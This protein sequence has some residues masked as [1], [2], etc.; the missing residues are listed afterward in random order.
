MTP[1]PNFGD[2]PIGPGQ[3]WTPS[4]SSLGITR[5]E[6]EFLAKTYWGVAK[7]GTL[8]AYKIV[9][10]AD[11]I[12]LTSRY[13]C[14]PSTS[15]G[16]SQYDVLLATAD[17]GPVAGAV[18]DTY[19]GGVPA[20][21]WFRLCVYAQKIKLRLGTTSDTRCTITVGQV[22]VCNADD[23]MFWLQDSTAANAAVQNRVGRCL[24]ATTN[25]VDNGNY[26]DC[27]LNLAF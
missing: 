1:Q 17:T 20:G 3:Y 9:K 25:G 13:L 23:G 7:D 10:N 4:N 27:E 8:R 12:T 16:R 5:Q 14:K 26:I 21:K 18:D 24:T 19:P 11:S 15:A 22:I 2:C 6:A